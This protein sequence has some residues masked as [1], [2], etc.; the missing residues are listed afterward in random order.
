[1]ADEDGLSL[2]GLRARLHQIGVKLTDTD[3]Q[4]ELWV[5]TTRDGQPVLLTNPMPLTDEERSEVFNS[6]KQRID[7]FGSMH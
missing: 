5:G 6:I 3:P 1:M 2:D 7:P 4:G